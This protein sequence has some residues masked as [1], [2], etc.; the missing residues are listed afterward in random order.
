MT[1]YADFF[2]IGTN[3][4]TQYVLAIDRN[5]S[6]LAS[7]YTSFHPARHPAARP[8][9]VGGR[10]A[11]LEVSVCGELAAS[12]LGVYLL[13]G[14]GITALSVGPAALPEIKKVVRSVPAGGCPRAGLQGA[15]GAGHGDCHGHPGG[16]SHSGSTC[17]SSPAAGHRPSRGDAMSLRLFTSESVTEGHPDKIADQI[18]DASWM[19]SSRDADARVA[20]EVMVTTGLVVVT[21]G[22]HRQLHPDY[23][24]LVRGTVS[25]IGYRESGWGIDGET[26]GVMVSVDR[27]SPDISRGSIP[28]GGGPGDDVRLRRG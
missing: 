20:C 4:L 19:T 1:R 22:D 6:K 9:R 16:A 11:G 24:T 17:P 3:D 15:G 13:L 14:L 18:S 28:G 12:P 23:A 5:N 26:C 10:E 27:Q 25:A 2:S 21:R 8:D 7:R